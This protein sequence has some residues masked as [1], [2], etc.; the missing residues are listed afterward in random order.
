MITYDTL[1]TFNLKN[2]K[3]SSSV[4][5][6]GRGATGKT[7]LITNILREMPNFDY[8]ILFDPIKNDNIFNKL[9]IH[10]YHS[11]TLATF[12]KYA[13][14]QKQKNKKG[15]VVFDSCFFENT[16]NDNNFKSS[17]FNGRH[18]N[19]TNIVT[20]QYCSID[21]T[22]ANYMDYVFLFREYSMSNKKKLYE[23]YGGHIDTCITFIKLL[24][25][26]T[27]NYGCLV[28]ERGQN[29]KMYKYKGDIS[30]SVSGN[31]TTNFK[32]FDIFKPTINLKDLIKNIGEICPIC[33]D[34]MSTEKDMIVTLCKHAYHKSCWDL[35]DKKSKCP[36]CRSET[37]YC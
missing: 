23:R 20:E 36:Y 1:P 35:Y 5:I 15:V 2:I 12:N 6:I 24:D 37:G 16:R 31:S 14:K 8:G 19:I 10:D 22:V 11:T 30:V 34:I 29:T 7:N 17:I 21:C 3:Q 13:L 25:D 27:Q 28:I 4:H 33:H 18:S 32:Q 26:A 9:Y